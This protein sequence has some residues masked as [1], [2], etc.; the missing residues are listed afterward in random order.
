MN[1]LVVIVCCCLFSMLKLH[2][3]HVRNLRRKTI[4]G[5]ICK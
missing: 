3:D 2:I 1:L 4:V 5:H